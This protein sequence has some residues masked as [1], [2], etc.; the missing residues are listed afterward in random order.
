MGEL[1]YFSHDFFHKV[2]GTSFYGETNYSFQKSL[3]VAC[4]VAIKKEPRLRTMDWIAE[5]RQRV[6]WLLTDM[7]FSNEKSDQLEV[8]IFIVI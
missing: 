6:N 8:G 7:D 5:N 2:L 4:E 1:N 3:E